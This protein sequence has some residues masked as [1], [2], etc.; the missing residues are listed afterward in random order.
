[1]PRKKRKVVVLNEYCFDKKLTE[2]KARKLIPKFNEKQAHERVIHNVHD[3]YSRFKSPYKELADQATVLKSGKMIHPISTRRLFQEYW[4]GKKELLVK[5]ISQVMIPHLRWE[6]E[7]RNNTR[8][9]NISNRLIAES[10]ASHVH[11]LGPF[12]LLKQNAPKAWEVEHIKRIYYRDTVSNPGELTTYYDTI[13]VKGILALRG[14]EFHF[15]PNDSHKSGGIFGP[16]FKAWIEATDYLTCFPKDMVKLVM[17]YY[18]CFYEESY[19]HVD[20]IYR[21]T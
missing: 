2:E 9:Y 11:Y 21:Y 14:H 3:E 1:M 15:F 5:E 17:Q 13:K 10:V 4:H 16:D 8:L 19:D 6:W 20:N 18:F 7:S 12:H